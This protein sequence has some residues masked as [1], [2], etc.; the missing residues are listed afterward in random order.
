M[1]YALDAEYSSRTSASASATDRSSSPTPYG[2]SQQP[3]SPVAPGVAQS[4]DPRPSSESDPEERPQIPA[5]AQHIALV[6]IL[7]SRLREPPQL[8]LPLP[9]F[10]TAS[11][12][13]G[14][15]SH[16]P[17]TSSTN[18]S[19]FRIMSAG[20]QSTAGMLQHRLTGNNNDDVNSNRSS[21]IEMNG[22]STPIDDSHV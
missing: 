16:H 1:Q 17:S 19:S 14:A 5:S 21:C 12:A 9:T 8:M 4:T 3:Y 22:A 11:A 7:F 15:P 10:S 20:S 6:G 18:R 13:T 2:Q